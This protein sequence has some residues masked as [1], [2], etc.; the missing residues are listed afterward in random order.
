M[1]Y[2]TAVDLGVYLRDQVTANEDEIDAV[3]TVASQA[4]DAHCQRTFT[5]PSAASERLFVPGGSTLLKV[6]DI[7]N[8]TDLAITVD[9]SALSSSDYQLEVSPGEVNTTTLTGRVRPYQYIRRLSGA[10]PCTAEA[11]VSI[12]ARW[13]W[14][15]VPAE[16][17][18]AV[19]LLAKDHFQMRDTRFGFVQ[20]GD[21]SRRIA[22]NGMVLSL[23]ADLRRVEAWGV[24]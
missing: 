22:E 7:A 10:W 8:T 3:A 21:F 12:T 14:P 1:A 17:P 2:V 23:L 18:Q 13:G 19:K 9:G 24:A 15:T 5:V 6:P 4:V 16:V 20:L 11:V